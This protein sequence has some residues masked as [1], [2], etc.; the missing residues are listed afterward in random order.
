MTAIDDPALLA[1]TQIVTAWVGAHEVAAGS[2]PGII[3]EVYRSLT[4]PLAMA[5]H[6][7]QSTLQKLA[8]AAVEV[9][10]SVFADHIVCLEDGK[11]V[12]MLKRHLR[13]A[14]RLSPEE[15]RAK[16]GL[17]PKYP[18]VAP[19]YAKKRSRLAKESGL[20]RRKWGIRTNQGAK[21]EKQRRLSL[22]G[23]NALHSHS[24]GVLSLGDQHVQDLDAYGTSRRIAGA[25]RDGANV[26]T[27][28]RDAIHNA[29]RNERPGGD[30]ARSQPFRTDPWWTSRG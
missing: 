8:P 14:H 2:L 11:S 12:T 28:H 3:R 24:P 5:P 4:D 10:K 1:T 17:P 27:G 7:G 20:G 9:R 21:H 29:H 22:A 19:N 30:I 25:P 15:Y 16:W 13:T 23:T 6:P 18:M 26:R